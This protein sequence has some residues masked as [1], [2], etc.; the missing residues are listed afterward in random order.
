M[1]AVIVK[2][3]MRSYEETKIAYDYANGAGK[4][5]SNGVYN[6]YECVLSCLN[7]DAMQCTLHFDLYETVLSL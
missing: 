1:L 3:K 4:V 2:T 6:L 5:E 7:N